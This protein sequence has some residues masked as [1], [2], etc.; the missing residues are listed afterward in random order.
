MGL[1]SLFTSAQLK[2]SDLPWYGRVGIYEHISNNLDTTGKLTEFGETL[3]D[4]EIF[5]KD[6]KIRWVAGGMDG[7]FG[8]HGGTGNAK[9]NAKKVASLVK[10]IA[11]NGSIRKKVELYNLLTKDSLLD[12]LDPSLEKIAALNIPIDPF[13][14]DFSKWLA[15]ESP[16]RGPVKF[17]I[18]LLGL[19]R[20]PQDMNKIKIL[21]RHEEFTLYAVV[22]VLNTYEN[23]ERHL[24]DLAKYVNGWG[25]IHIVE[26]LADTKDKEIKDWLLLDGYKNSVMYEYLAYTAAVSGDLK[27]ALEAE[28]INDKV[29]ES[30]G[31]IIEALLNGG[32]AEDINDFAAAAVVLDLYVSH[33]A[34]DVELR[35]THFN[36]L[37]LIE[38]YLEDEDHD[39]NELTEN[40][41]T[42]DKRQSVLAKSKNITDRDFWSP[43][44]SSN[45]S[46]TNDQEFWEIKRAASYLG[47]NLWPTIWQRIN[48]EP[49]N[50]TLWFDVMQQVEEKDIDRVIDLVESVL[51]M[52]AIATGP[53]NEMGLGEEYKY[54]QILDTVL[55]D[56]GRYPGH[57]EKL[58]I[59]GLQSPVVRNRVMAVKSIH[60]WENKAITEGI[61]NVLEKVVKQE[62][63]TELKQDMK[64]I[65]GNI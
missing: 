51:P 2:G 20:A 36:I 15:F 29:I 52:N 43:L 5:N 50:T 7:A 65:L 57:G 56:L 13:L 39:W 40:G 64:S 11:K 26:R 22:A 17:G 14:H 46:T 8:L 53:A 9:N 48:S 62:P 63:D 47:I 42:P 54:H 45:L 24:Y 41:W 60:E 25:K 59:I 23:S 19:I 31:E 10:A 33:L 35:I 1:L 28:E 49:E 55:Q 38:D 4:D 27:K 18:A 21:G 32:P 34:E 44:V 6:N 12:F 61:I 16:D 3:S 37:K 58:I 30:A